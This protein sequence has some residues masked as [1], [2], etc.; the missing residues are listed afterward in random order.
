MVPAVV[1][2]VL[3]A[4]IVDVARLAGASTSTVS[5]VINGTR[6][7]SDEKRNRVLAA[8]EMTGYRQDSVARA[9]RRSRTDSVGLIVSSVSQSVFG[10]M[11]R[12]V[13]HQAV[14][15]GYTL[16][17]ANSAEDGARES[18]A[19]KALV[20]RKV[21]GLI[22]APAARAAWRE[23]DELCRAGTPVVVMDRASKA[24]TDMV[25]VEN[26]GPMKTLTEHMIAHGHERIALATGDMKVS[27]IAERTKGFLQA[28][29]E[30]GIAV[31][32]RYLLTGSGLAE[33][34]SGQVGR[35]LQSA[36]APT[37]ILSTSTETAIGTLEAARELG[38]EAPRDLA[39]ATFDGFAH[40]DLFRPRVTSVTQPAFEIGETA[41]RLLL[42]RL[43]SDPPARSRTVRLAP[44]ITYR[45]SCGCA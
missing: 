22:V 12:G 2:G 38:L 16:L 1:G 4:T 35:L 18:A 9:L 11:I 31:P 20:A 6:Y 24:R 5:H 28:I 3:P 39:F 21:D 10:D 34:V 44:R 32:D 13:E 29:S 37:A 8:I 43:S 41:M 17:L 45:E 15:A 26:V 7:V 19:L 33:E 23:V 27:T 30:A 42:D 14:E 25:G 36:Q 40:P